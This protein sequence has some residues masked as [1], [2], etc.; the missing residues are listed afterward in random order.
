[1]EKLNAQIFLT[2]AETGSFRKTADLLGYT[3]AGISYI[4]NAMEEEIGVTLFIRDHGGVRLS[5][6]GEQLYP[7]MVQLESWEHQF[8][9]AVDELK[10]LEKGSVRVQIFDSI[11]IH[12]I[13]G[14]IRK[15][16]ED[17]PG[18]E[19]ELISEEDSYQAEKMVLNGEVDCGFFLTEVQS[20]INAFPLMEDPLN[21]IVAPD[22]P[23]ADLERFPMDQLDQ[24]PYISMKYEEHTGIQNI[25]KE[26]GI[27]PKIA[28]CMDNDYAAM[29]M[30]SQGLGYCIFPK[31]L[32]QDIP[33]EIRCIEL[34]EPQKRVIS[35]GTRDLKTCSKACCK[36]IEYT[37]KW[38]EE[39]QV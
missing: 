36:F 1:M 5:K 12:W 6:E 17:Y 32:L 22:H 11:S 15:F 10:G 33:Y 35:I 39:H 31:L 21:V 37:R 2:V 8:K 16:R 29:A 25:F 9:Q 23:L 14:I 18:I 3:Q 13:P 27:S 24:Y 30:V 19:I 28:F 34:E 26:R 4:V 7:Y 20:K 38:V